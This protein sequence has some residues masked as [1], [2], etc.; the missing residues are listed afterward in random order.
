MP[1]AH[2]SISSSLGA[3]ESKGKCRE[4]SDALNPLVDLLNVQLKDEADDAIGEG[5]AFHSIWL[6]LLIRGRLWQS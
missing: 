6:A 1:W 2:L 5:L 4:N 3:I